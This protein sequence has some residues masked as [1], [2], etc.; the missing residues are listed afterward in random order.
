M[1]KKFSKFLLLMLVIFVVSTSS[2][3]CL[4][5]ETEKSTNSVTTSETN[6]ETNTTGDSTSTTPEIYSGDLY[7][8]DN[9]VVMDKYVDGNVFILGNNVK[10][11]G[12]VNG[13]L[14]VLANKITFDGSLVRYSIFACGNSV[15]YNNCGTYE[16]DVYIAANNLETTYTSYVARDIKVLASKA[17]FKSA[18]GRDADL[19]CN[20][21]ELG[22]GKDIPMVYGD[23][24]YTSDNEI[25]VPEGAVPTG[26]VTYTKPSLIDNIFD[27]LVGFGTCIVT[28]LAIYIIL[29]KLTPSFV[30]KVCNQKF[31]VKN[32]LKAFGIGLATIALVLLFTMLLIGTYVGM[33]LGII[34]SLLFAILYIIAVPML[35]ISITN[36]LKPALKIEKDSMFY[37]VLSLVSIILYGITLIPFVGV[38]LNFLIK[39]T[40]IGL[41]I[42]VFLPHKELSEEEKI[43]LEETKKI[44]KENKEKRKQ[45]KLEAKSAIKQEKAKNKEANKQEKTKA[46]KEVKSKEPKKQKDSKPKEAKKKDKKSK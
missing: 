5:H 32:L 42:N 1:L 41:V 3:T 27:I 12:Q 10:I 20:S 25:V 34:L 8:F 17:T 22:E 15:Y 39:V 40:S 38:I 44:A 33:L 11:T 30:Q 4:A 35:A 23:L 37:L 29:N 28:A 6:E 16:S 19:I 46:Q 43:A 18:V 36:E 26:S 45:E 9:N 14:Y 13:N 24:R 21:L 2:L 31:S 7:L